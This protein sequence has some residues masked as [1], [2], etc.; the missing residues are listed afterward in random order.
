MHGN[1]SGDDDAEAGM[2]MMAASAA[3]GGTKALKVDRMIPCEGVR[4]PEGDFQAC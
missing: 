1:G 3:R 4:R 2:W